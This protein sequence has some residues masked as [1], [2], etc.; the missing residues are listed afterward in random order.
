MDLGRFLDLYMAETQEHLRALNRCLLDLEAGGGAES[1]EEAFR[2][3]HTIKGMSA[4]MGYRVVTDLAHKLEERL[5]EI[6][7]GKRSAEPALIDEL[8]ASADALERSVALAVVTQTAADTGVGALDLSAVVEMERPEDVEATTSPPAGSGASITACVPDAFA[9]PGTELTAC[10]TLRPGAQL[11][12]ARALIA[13]RNVERVAIVL[14]S[15]PEEFGENFD[16]LFQLFIGEGGDR[17]QVEAAIRAAGDVVA[18]EFEAPVA[19]P[20]PIP[21]A[22]VAKQEAARSRPRQ[23]RVDQRRIDALADGV[24][25]LAILRTRTEELRKLAQLDEM[26]DVLE[27]MRRLVDEVQDVALGMR[28]VPVGDVFDRFPRMVRDAARSLGKEIDFAIE[29][30]EIELDRSVL[31]EIAD[32]LV[33]LLRNAIDHGL[34]PMDERESNGKS[35]RGRLVLRAESGRGSVRVQVQDD[36]RGVNKARVHAKAIQ[37]GVLAPNAATDLT[38]EDLLRVLSEPG[39]STASEITEVSGRGVGLDAVLNRIRALGGIVELKSLEGEGTTFTLRLPITLAVA[40]SMHVRVC[41]EHYMV[42]TTHI[43]EVVDVRDDLVQ[44]I[45]GVEYLLVR[46]EPVRMVRL[47]AMLSQA[48]SGL[49]SAAVISEI[50]ERRTALAVDQLVGREQIVV[51]TFDPAVGTLPYFSGVTL[52]ADGRPALV[53]DP[54]SVS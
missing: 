27:R 48:S 42:P 32:P 24:G 30:R 43:A 12:A 10:V 15:S 13:R 53:L 39:F 20:A 28:M 21:T 44:Q 40:A 36:G 17:A 31:E 8:L 52:L 2:S 54:I 37:R 6:R 3:A 49:E 41:G 33:H 1:M 23:V 16:G 9:P 7:T 18:V 50:G 46:G 38:D 19:A 22:R 11:H 47:G 26:A 14:G 34:E 4:T 29:G 51:K 35:P 45:D 5:D 25:E